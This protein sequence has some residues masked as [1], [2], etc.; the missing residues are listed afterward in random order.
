[1]LI[2]KTELGLFPGLGSK[3][4]KEVRKASKYL[5]FLVALIPSDCLGSQGRG[6]IFM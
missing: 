5:N 6:H 4:R 1:M 3:G 2:L